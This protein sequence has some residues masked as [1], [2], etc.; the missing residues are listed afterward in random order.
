MDG[1][2]V[3]RKS[4]Q[5]EVFHPTRVKV[6]PGGGMEILSCSKSIFREAGF[7]ESAEKPKPLQREARQGETSGAGSDRAAR[8]AAAT[9]RDLALCNDF[10]WFVTLTLDAARIDRYDLG[11]IVKRMTSWL[12]N[13]VRRRGLRYVL[14]PEQ[15]QDGAFH[16]HGFFNDIPGFFVPSGTW[17]IPGKDK[18]VRP[19]SKAQAAAWA[20]AGDAAGYHEVF[21]APEWEFGFTT[22]IKLYG[23]YEAA[24]AYVCKYIRKQQETGKLGGRW[25]YSGGELRRPEIVLSDYTLTELMQSGEVFYKFE[26]PEARLLFG[27]LRKRGEGGPAEERAAEN[28]DF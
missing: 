1:Y 3:L 14:I 20:K 9:V 5:A 6:Y 13:R 16:F 10:A 23:S 24:V 18:P 15:H 25:Y 21:N 12:D 2:K 22:S 8:R 4:T 27:M 17:K 7:E 26:V 28:A 11:A 19:R